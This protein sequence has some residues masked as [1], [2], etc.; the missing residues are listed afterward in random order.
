MQT[1]ETIHLDGRDFRG[2]SQSL[3]AA[4]DDFLLAHLRRSGAMEVIAN[5]LPDKTKAENMLTSIM[6]AGETFSV[7]AGCLTEE[8]RAWTRDEARRN[9][10]TFAAITDLGEKLAMRGALVG[11]VVGF[12]GLGARSSA[13]SPKSSAA[14]GADPNT[15]SAD[16]GTSET[17]PTSS[18][19]SPDAIQSASSA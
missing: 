10:A 4:Q 11:F 8:G 12:F 18:E 17:L 7:L 5:E 16:P 13:T 1:A 3:T 15:S 9:A 6:L 14:S 19:R 2:I